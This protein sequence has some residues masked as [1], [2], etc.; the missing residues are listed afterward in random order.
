MTWATP[1]ARAGLLL[2]AFVLSGAAAFAQSSSGS[3]LGTV[4]DQSAA[5]VVG[6]T[7]SVQSEALIGGVQRSETD[8]TGA[9]RLADLPPGTYTLLVSRTGL[10][11]VRRDGLQLSAGGTLLIDVTLPVGPVSDTIDVREPSPMVDVTSPAANQNISSSFLRD[12]PT[13]RWVPAL[14]NL[15]PGVGND[16][17]FGGTQGS[18]AMTVDGLDMTGPDFG[19]AGLRL[20]QNWLQEVQV[21]S[22]GA[23]A[24]IGKTTGLSANMVLRSGSNRLSG[25]ADLR[26]T[27][28]GWV[29]RNTE[30]LSSSQQQSFSPRRIDHLLDI[31]AHA[32]FPVVRDR[33]WAFA[34]LR[35]SSLDDQPAGY[36]GSKWSEARD[37]V[38]LGKLTTALPGAARLEGFVQ[39]GDAHTSATNLGPLVDDTALADRDE[40]QVNW[41]VRL[42]L[43]LGSSTLLDARYGGSDGAYDSVSHAPN[44]CGGPPPHQDRL[45][46]RQWGN[47]YYC[48]R[49]TGGAQDVSATLSHYADAFLGRHEFKAGVEFERTS[50]RE[51]SNTP[52]GI[53]YFDLGAVPD[54][55]EIWEGYSFS[56]TLQRASAYVEDK[57]Q[58]GSRIT[59]T[60]GLRLDV[61]TGA[62]P[63]TED[64]ATPTSWSPRLGVAVD[65]TSDH[66]TVLRAH[67]GRY[68]DRLFAKRIKFVDT[69]D[70]SPT[71]TV[72]V[73]APGQFV[74][75]NRQ[76]LPNNVAIDPDI[77][78]GYVD[79]FVVGLERQLW[80]NVSVLGQYIARRFSEFTGYVDTASQWS[81]VTRPDA[82]PDGI[83]GNADD[84]P[85]LTVYNLLN[86]GQ[87][88]YLFTNP[89]DATRRYD[90]AQFV[91]RKRD[92]KYGQAQ[93][94][95][96]WQKSEGTVGN[97]T[98]SNAGFNDT[99]LGGSFVNPNKA[100]NAY[101]RLPFDPIH[102]FKVLATGRLSLWSGL[103]GS[104]VYRYATGN[105]WQRDTAVRQLT[106]G[107]QR[108]HA[109]PRGAR[110]LDATNLLDLRFEQAVR[111]RG[112]DRLGLYLD[113]FNVTNRGVATAVFNVSGPSFA[114]PTAWTD[115]RIFRAGVRYAF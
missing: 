95:Y 4:R 47:V 15:V 87:A 105:A 48:Y 43:P 6:A 35:R 25:L 24:A 100:I 8:D 61:S 31:G 37:T 54:E 66:R 50:G 9:F 28:P 23:G 27:R 11:A 13:T 34:G 68:T 26:F 16:V 36:S 60:P 56:A 55:A 71:I 44:T 96:T 72:Q 2:T 94:S 3:L 21:S 115:P 12:L 52:G 22:L 76:A 30:S 101:G 88:F 45:T 104:A 99:G 5:V 64:L 80:A 110:R 102:E 79:Q 74:E 18:N 112:N 107:Q 40:T 32:G 65:L 63:D 19:Q 97:Q 46:G 59:L 84:G 49:T 114:M 73:L 33:V 103:S 1:T 62:T 14:V 92:T 70:W 41:N 106:Q 7:V 29:S 77:A 51:A 111:V 57:W 91:L 89:P 42:T 78:N 90:A 81:A 53:A 20:D 38:F 85:P 17:A 83:A 82:G 98:F 58:T 69:S 93:I 10:A 39:T 67:V 109:E 108:V 86:P 113:V 75:L